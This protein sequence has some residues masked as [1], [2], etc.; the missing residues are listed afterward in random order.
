VFFLIAILVDA[1]QYFIAV[2]FAFS[3]WWMML[4]TF[5]CIYCTFMTIHLWILSLRL[6]PL[7]GDKTQINFEHLTCYPLKAVLWRKK[8]NL[9]ALLSLSLSFT[10]LPLNWLKYHKFWAGGKAQVVEHL[11]RKLK[12]LGPHPHTPTHKLILQSGMV[13][14]ICSLSP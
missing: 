2:W 8:L 3:W 10:S 4:I 12:V 1:R 9:L 7:Q 11:H 14:N 5:S 13:L 6:E